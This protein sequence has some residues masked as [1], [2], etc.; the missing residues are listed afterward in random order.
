MTIIHF[1]R[2]KFWPSIVTS[3]Q[4]V[5]NDLGFD[6]YTY[7]DIERFYWARKP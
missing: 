3:K 4:I 1:F 2:R 7:L 5:E 6:G